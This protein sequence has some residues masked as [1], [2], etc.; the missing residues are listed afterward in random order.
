MDVIKVILIA[1]VVLGTAG[2]VG[3]TVVCTATIDVLPLPFCGAL[4]DT[5]LH[6]SGALRGWLGW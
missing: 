6:Y 4:L 5:L 1:L 2:L 3:L